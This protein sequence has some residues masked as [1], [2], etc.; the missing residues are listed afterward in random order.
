MVYKKI[1][2]RAPKLTAIL[3]GFVKLLRGII[4]LKSIPNFFS[5]FSQYE[6][7][8]YSITFINYGEFGF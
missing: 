2:K 5:I 1:F 6:I 3:I 7:A 8:A 4:F